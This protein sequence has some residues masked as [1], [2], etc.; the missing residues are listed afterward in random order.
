[1][2]KLKRMMGWGKPLG[3]A[4]CMSLHMEGQV[5]VAFSWARYSHCRWL[6]CC[7]GAKQR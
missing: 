6:H 7:S 2:V 1:M 5:E 4:P 3:M